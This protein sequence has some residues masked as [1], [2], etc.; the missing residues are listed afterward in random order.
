[1]DEYVLGRCGFRHR[2]LSG[3]RLPATFEERIPRTRRGAARSGTRTATAHASLRIRVPHR[4]RAAFSAAAA[5][6]GNRRTLSAARNRTDA[7]AQPGSHRKLD[8]TAVSAKPLS[9][10]HPDDFHV[11]AESGAA[12]GAE[13]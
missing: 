5:E 3:V 10:R 6:S 2:G 1:M 4:A 9:V 7:A 8:Y 13:C 11:S 12:S